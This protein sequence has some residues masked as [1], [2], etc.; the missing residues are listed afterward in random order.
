MAD[1]YLFDC[2]LNYYRY[3]CCDEAGNFDPAKATELGFSE[4]Q[5]SAIIAALALPVAE[6]PEER[7]S[8]TED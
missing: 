4:S 2:D 6:S 7:P 8:D 1:L 5:F 3:G